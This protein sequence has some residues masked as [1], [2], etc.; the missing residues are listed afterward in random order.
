MLCYN[1]AVQEVLVRANRRSSILAI[2]VLI[3]AIVWI[4][5]GCDKSEPQAGGGA[6]TK[7]VAENGAVQAGTT[8]D[9]RTVATQP[10]AS[11][12]WVDQQR[13]EFPPARMIV[14]TKD[15]QLSALLFSDDPPA[16]I[17]D[18]YTGNSYYLEI[19]DPQLVEGSTTLA[20]AL[21]VFKAPNSERAETVSGIF[22]QGRRRHLQPFEVRAE[23][24]ND[25]APIKVILGGTFLMF[26]N[27]IDNAAQLP[28]RLVHVRAELEADVKASGK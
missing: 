4:T 3:G 19:T 17:D 10:A 8:P 12:V 1:T 24:A 22:L 2:L 28:G 7:P 9:P 15:D 26:D 5:V 16:A 18:R 27:E 21:W 14:R 20:G 11:Y 13:Y 25:T 23:F 6:A